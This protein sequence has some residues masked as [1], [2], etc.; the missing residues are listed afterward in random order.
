MNAILERAAFGGAP[1]DEEDARELIVAA[2]DLL[3][4]V[5]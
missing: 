5:E 2:N 4:S 3:D 1:V